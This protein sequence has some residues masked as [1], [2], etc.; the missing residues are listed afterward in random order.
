[1][2]ALTRARAAGRAG[3]HS[4]ESSSFPDLNQVL[5][6]PGHSAD[7]QHFAQ[8]WRSDQAFRLQH[9][10]LYLAL[11][12]LRAYFAGRQDTLT[13]GQTAT[14]REFRT[15]AES[16]AGSVES[17]A[18]R[19]LQRIFADTH[20]ERET[21]AHNVLEVL[22]Q[23]PAAAPVAAT[24]PGSPAGRPFAEF[25]AITSNLH[26]ADGALRVLPSYYTL[27]VLPPEGLGQTQNA[28]A[29]VSLG[30]E[31]R[32][33]DFQLFADGYFGANIVPDGA[34]DARYHRMALRVGLVEYS[35]AIGGRRGGNGFYGSLFGHSRTGIGFGYAWCDRLQHADGSVES[36]NNSTFQVQSFGDSELASIGY[37]PFELGIRTL[38][39]NQSLFL[40]TAPSGLSATNR[41]PLEFSLTWHLTA[42][43]IRGPGAVPH[44][45]A[46]WPGVTF[47][48]LSMFNNFWI[49]NNRRLQESSYEGLR[50]I[51][52]QGD[53]SSRG[54][55]AQTNLGT[56][57]NGVLGGFGEMGT[58]RRLQTSLRYGDTAQRIV[59][60]GL[61][62]VEMA[63]L[64]IG[65]GTTPGETFDPATRHASI[66]LQ[67]Q[68]FQ[69]AWPTVLTRDALSLLGAVG[70]FGDTESVTRLGTA[71]PSFAHFAIAHG[72]LTLGGLAMILTSGDGS[73]N[74]FF[75]MSIL[76]NNPPNT[77]RIEVVGSAYD[78][79]AQR[80]QY[81]RL[82]I[83]TMFLA[84]GVG[85]FADWLIG[86]Y[87]NFLPAEN[88]RL[89]QQLNDREAAPAAPIRPTARLG[90]N[91]DAQTGF[92][93]TAQG[94]F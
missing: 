22:G 61:M 51:S 44:P 36:C 19:N 8:Q 31:F 94:T 73:G 65:A 39:N 57:F 33:G 52:L 35:N 74:G 50:I 85:G 10:T 6:D 67:G 40:N 82:E 79:P 90:F 34:P 91:T 16:H 38:F 71:S 17:I 43:E 77:P 56:F 18:L 86:H 55:Y 66:N 20:G 93:L 41:V 49:G 26:F 13:E 5:L 92:M 46:T 87:A 83:G 37:G 72:V 30:G 2:T 88:A 28:D 81:L 21:R 78:Y 63:A 3:S 54:N 11:D 70:A 84:Y 60:G 27:G 75:N 12:A 32:I 64:A 47:T 9:S 45:E 4:P 69:L 7:P 76:G 42:P 80:S 53:L 48:G 15:F 23:P 59:V 58:A 62:G 14:F 25:Q 1:M 89:R 68:A 24:A 29:G